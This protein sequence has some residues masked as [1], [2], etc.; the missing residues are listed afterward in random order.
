MDKLSCVVLAA[1]D[2]KRMKSSLPKVLCEVLFEPMLGWVLDAAESSGIRKIGV[3]TGSGADKVGAY[4]AARGEYST[5]LQEQRLGT[6]HAVMQA[7]EFFKDDDFTL[8]LCGDAPFVTAEI[9]RKAFDYHKS[10]GN[11]ITVISS[12]V[13]NPTG[14]GRIFRDGN[15]RFVGIVEEK[16]CTDE[17]RKITEIN[18][19]IYWFKSAKLC[20]LLKQVE[21]NNANGEFYLTDTVQICL[22]NGGTVSRFYSADNSVA[23]GANTR[24]GLME[25]NRVARDRVVDRLLDGGV[26]IPLCDGIIVGKNVAIGADTKILPNTIIKGDTTIGRGCTIGANSMIDNCTIGDNVVLNNVQAAEST[27][28]SGARVGPFVHIR[29]NSTIKSGVKIGD[30]VEVKNSVIGEKTSIAH[31]TYVGDSDVGS[32]V[33]FGCGVVTA[34]YD[35]IN[36]HRTVIGDNAF[37]GCNTNL[38]APVKVGDNA[39]TAAGSTITKDVPDNALAVERGQLRVR[40]NWDKGIQRLNKKK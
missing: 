31:L 29:P 37:L 40:E 18:S 33:N 8:V 23:L 2:G 35:G 4:L 11:D 9:I 12:G 34:N 15:G 3:V 30:F 39:T 6:A 5:F 36:K 26:E 22:E 19:G 7:E 1:G 16:D 24:K 21:N 13:D 28:E 20:E 10:E 14:Y 38:I 32:R 25:L 17:Q 27:V